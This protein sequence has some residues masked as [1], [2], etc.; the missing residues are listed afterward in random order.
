MAGSSM[1]RAARQSR[2]RSGG[3]A[4][5]GGG[6]GASGSLGDR[7]CSDTEEERFWIEKDVEF[8]SAI[9][10]R[11]LALLHHHKQ[12]SEAFLSAVLP[13][14]RSRSRNDAADAA[15][16]SPRSEASQGFALRV[17]V[18]DFLRQDW[19]GGEIGG[20]V[21]S[22][23]S[24][25]A[26]RDRR[27]EETIERE[28]DPPKRVS[29]S[30]PC[31]N[32][33]A[34]ENLTEG[35]AFSRDGR[36]T[37]SKDPQGAREEASPSCDSVASPVRR[38]S[39][40]S[41]LGISQPVSSEAGGEAGP[42]SVSSSGATAV[43]AGF[44]RNVP[45]SSRRGATSEGGE[46]SP[47]SQGGNSAS[48][49]VCSSQGPSPS[50]VVGCQG[51]PAPS[52]LSQ[53]WPHHTGKILLE[54]PSYSGETGRII[55]HMWPATLLADV[56]P[57]ALCSPPL[58]RA[59]KAA[60][61]PKKK[62][63][64]R[65]HARTGVEK[66]NFEES[67]RLSCGTEG[68]AS[69]GES[70]KRSPDWGRS[71]QPHFSS[72][73]ADAKETNRETAESEADG[74]K[75]DAGLGLSAHW[76]EETGKTEEEMK[77]SESRR[78]GDPSGGRK[79]G[80]EDRVREETPRG[81][82]GAEKE[83]T[84][85]SGEGGLA[86]AAWE[87]SKPK[88]LN[89]ETG[90]REGEDSSPSS[91]EVG[92]QGER[93][94]SRCGSVEGGER[95]SAGLRAASDD[96]REKSED[97][98]EKENDVGERQPAKVSQEGQAARDEGTLQNSRAGA[99]SLPASATVLSG[100]KR[101]LEQDGDSQGPRCGARSPCRASERS[102][103][104]ETMSRTAGR[105]SAEKWKREEAFCLQV[106]QNRSIFSL[107]PGAHD[108][109][110][111]TSLHEHQLN[112]HLKY[113]SRDL[114]VFSHSGDFK[115]RATSARG[116]SRRSGGRRGAR[117]AAGFDCE[118][119]AE[120]DFSSGSLASSTPSSPV[121]RASGA[122]ER[123][124][125]RRG[126]DSD[127]TPRR[128]GK[129]D[130]RGDRPAA[131][132][133][134][135]GV[136]AAVHEKAGA[137]S[138]GPSRAG[139][140]EVRVGGR[141]PSGE[142]E[143][144]QRSSPVGR[145]AK[146]VVEGGEEDP[147]EAGADDLFV[148]TVHK[149]WNGSMR[150]PAF[151]TCR[152]PDAF[153]LSMFVPPNVSPADFPEDTNAQGDVSAFLAV[154]ME[155]ATTTA[156]DWDAHANALTPLDGYNLAEKP[157]DCGAVTA[158]GKGAAE[159]LGA[160]R[161]GPEGLGFAG[162]EACRGHLHATTGSCGTQETSRME[163]GESVAQMEGERRAKLGKSVECDW[164]EAHPAHARPVASDYPSASHRRDLSKDGSLVKSPGGGRRRRRSS[165]TGSGGERTSSGKR[166]RSK[167]EKKRSPG[168][169]PPV[170][171]QPRSSSGRFM[172][173][174]SL[175]EVSPAAPTSSK[176]RASVSPSSSLA[177]CS[178]SPR[179]RPRRRLPLPTVLSG[180][181]P[182]WI[183]CSEGVPGPAPVGQG[184]RGP[185]GP[186]NA[187]VSS[188]ASHGSCCGRA[189]GLG[190][191]GPCW[192]RPVE[193]E[194]GAPFQIPGND[195][196]G[197]AGMNGE[198]ALD[199]GSE[200]YGGQARAEEREQSHAESEARL[201]SSSTTNASPP[202]HG[203]S[204]SSS[205]PPPER[206][207]PCLEAEG[208]ESSHA[209]FPPGQNY[210][211]LSPAT[212]TSGSSPFSPGASLF[213]RASPAGPSSPGSTSSGI[214]PSQSFASPPSSCP[215]F[216]FTGTGG[217]GAPS[218]AS[219]YH[220][221]SFSGRS[222]ACGEA[223]AFSPASPYPPCRPCA[224]IPQGAS[225]GPPPQF[226]GPAYQ[227]S[228]HLSP[229]SSA[230][231]GSVCAGPVSEAFS[232]VR[233]SFPSACCPPHPYPLFSPCPPA[234][235]QICAPGHPFNSYP[236][237]ASP[238]PELHCFSSAP[239][240]PCSSFSC[241]PPYPPPA[242]F[243]SAPETSSSSV[244]SVDPVASLSP[245]GAC[246]RASSAFS[247]STSSERSEEA[248][249]VPSCQNLGSG[250]THPS[251]FS[252][253]AYPVLGGGP[254]DTALCRPPASTAPP[255]LVPFTAFP[256]FPCPPL[257]GPGPVGEF[258]D[259]RPV[260]R[261]FPF[262]P[263]SSPA[264]LTL[265][266]FPRP[267]PPAFPGSSA[268]FEPASRCSSFL[269]RGEPQTVS[270]S[271]SESVAS[272]LPTPPPEILVPP[273]FGAG[274]S[275]KPFP[276]TC[277]LYP[278]EIA[279]SFR[280]SEKRK[281][282]V[283][284]GV[285]LELLRAQMTRV[286][287]LHT[288]YANVETGKRFFGERSF[289]DI[290]K[291]NARRH[292]AGLQPLSLSP[293]P[294]FNS[295]AAFFVPLT[296]ETEVPRSGS[297]SSPHTAAKKTKAT[298]EDSEREEREKR[299]K[300]EERGRRDLEEKI[301][302][303]MYSR[304]VV[305]ATT[306]H[307]SGAHRLMPLP[308]GK[309][310]A[311]GSSPQEL[312]IR[313]RDGECLHAS[314]GASEG[315]G[316]PQ[317]KKG[318][319]EDAQ[320]EH[321]VSLKT[322]A[323]P[324]TQEKRET[325]DRG[326][327]AVALSTLSP[328][329]TSPA[330]GAACGGQS[331]KVSPRGDSAAGCAE[332]G[333]ACGVTGE[334]KE[335][336]RASAQEEGEET[337]VKTEG[338]EGACE[339]EEFTGCV[340]VEEGESVGVKDVTEKEKE[341]C[342]SD[343]ANGE[344]RREQSEKE[345]GR[346]KDLV[347]KQTPF[348]SAGGEKENRG[349]NGDDRESADPVSLK[350][351]YRHRE[352]SKPV[353]DVA[354]PTLV[355]EEDAAVR[356]R[357]ESET[358]DVDGPE[359][360]GELLEGRKDS[361]VLSSRNATEDPDF[362]TKENEKQKAKGTPVASTAF[363]TEVENLLWRFS[364]LM[365]EKRAMCARL[366]MSIE[367]EKRPDWRAWAEVEDRMLRHYIEQSAKSSLDTRHTYT[368]TQQSRDILR[369]RVSC[370]SSGR[371]PPEWAERAL[372]TVCGSGED[373]DEDPIMFCDGCYQPV[374]FLCLG[375]KAVSSYEEFVKAS[376]MRRQRR[377]AQAGGDQGLAPATAR[378]RG[379]GPKR[380]KKKAAERAKEEKKK[381]RGGTGDLLASAGFGVP[382]PGA[383]SGD[384]AGTS[385]PTEGDQAGTGAGP[386]DT[387]HNT[388][389]P[390]CGAGGFAFR[391]DEEEWLC[392]VCEWLRK[393]LPQLDD[394]LALAA[395]RLAAGPRS[396]SEAA[397]CRGSYVGWHFE[398]L[399]HFDSWVKPQLLAL[400]YGDGRRRKGKGRLQV[401]FGAPQ[402]SR[403]DNRHGRKGAT[404]LGLPSGD[405]DS[406]GM[407][408]AHG[409]YS[410]QELLAWP[411][412]RVVADA[413]CLG[414]NAQ[415]SRSSTSRGSAARGPGTGG[416]TGGIAGP[417][418]D[419]SVFFRAEKDEEDRGL[420][421]LELDE[422]GGRPA[423]RG[424]GP[425]P[426]IS[427][428]AQTMLG[429]RT[430]PV[431]A[432]DEET[433][434]QSSSREGSVAGSK[435]G[436]LAGDGR[437][438]G[439][440]ERAGDRFMEPE[441]EDA[442]RAKGDGD[443]GRD[444]WARGPR[445]ASETGVGASGKSAREKHPV[446]LAAPE[447]ATPATDY[448]RRVPYTFSDSSGDEG[449]SG[450][451]GDT[452]FLFCQ[453]TAGSPTAS[454]PSSAAHRT[455]SQEDD[456]QGGLFSGSAFSPSSASMR[457]GAHASG[458]FSPNSAE[459]GASLTSKHYCSKDPRRRCVVRVFPVPGL[460]V[461]LRI[462]VCALCGYD[463]F[464][465]GGG[466]ARKTEKKGVW[467]HLRCALSLNAT[468]MDRVSYEADE[469][470]SRLR[471][472]FCHHQGPAP[473]HCGHA[474]CQ[475]TY[476]VSCATAT[477]GCMVDWD[478]G[479][480][481]IFCSQHAKNKAPTL[482]LRK[483]QAN[484]EREAVKRREE[485]LPGEW[486]IGAGK[487]RLGIALQSL[488]F[489]SY[490]GL[491]NIFSD[492]L[493]VPALRL[494]ALSPAEKTETPQ[495]LEALCF[496][497]VDPALGVHASPPGAPRDEAE[498]LERRR[499]AQSREEKAT[500]VEEQRKG[501]TQTED[502]TNREKEEKERQVE[503]GSG[504]RGES[505]S[506]DGGHDEEEERFTRKLTWRRRRVA[507]SDA[508]D[509]EG[510]ETKK[511]S[512]EENAVGRTAE[513]A[514]ASVERSR[515]C[516]M[517]ESAST[518]HAKQEV[519]NAGELRRKTDGDSSPQSHTPK[520]V[521]VIEGIEKLSRDD[522]HASLEEQEWKKEK[523]EE[524]KEKRNGETNDVVQSGLP[525]GKG[526]EAGCQSVGAAA[527]R[528]QG[529]SES[530]ATHKEPQK[531]AQVS[532]LSS[533]GDMTRVR[534]AGEEPTF[535]N[536]GKNDETKPAM[537]EDRGNV[538]VDEFRLSR[539]P[540]NQSRRLASLQ[541]D[542][543]EDEKEESEN[544]LA[545]ARGTGESRLDPPSALSASVANPVAV[546]DPGGE[547][548]NVAA[549][550]CSSP[551]SVP[552]GRGGPFSFA[553]QERGRS[554][555]GAVSGESESAT[556]AVAGEGEGRERARQIPNACGAGEEAR[557]DESRLD[558]QSGSAKDTPP[559]FLPSRA[560]DMLSLPSSSR[561]GETA[562]SCL[563][564]GPTPPGEGVSEPASSRVGSLLEGETGVGR[565]KR[566]SHSQAGAAREQDGV[567]RG[568][569][570][571]PT[572]FSSVDDTGASH[573]DAK[574]LEGS[575]SSL[576]SF[577]A[578]DREGGR[579]HNAAPGHKGA[580][581]SPTGVAAPFGEPV[582]NSPQSPFE[583][584][585]S[586]PPFSPD[587]WGE[588]AFFSSTSSF[589]SFSFNSGNPP[590]SS[591][592]P[593]APPRKRRGRPPLSRRSQGATHK[594][595]LHRQD[596]DR[597]SS[598]LKIAAGGGLSR[599]G[600][601][602][603]GGA[604]CDRD[605]RR[606]LHFG[607][608]RG[609]GMNLPERGPGGRFLPR[610]HREKNAQ[611]TPVSDSVSTS[612]YQKQRPV[613]LSDLSQG[614]SA[615]RRDGGGDS[616]GE[617]ESQENRELQAREEALHQQ[618]MR[619]MQI[620]FH[621]QAL[622]RERH[623][624]LLGN[625]FALT[626]LL[627][628][629]PDPAGALGL[630]A[631]H[632][633]GMPPSPLHGNSPATFFARRVARLL[634]SPVPLAIRRT[635]TNGSVGTAGEEK[636][637]G[638][639]GGAGQADTATAE[640]GVEEGPSGRAG[641]ERG[642]G[643]AQEENSKKDEKESVS[644]VS[645]GAADANPEAASRGKEALTK[646]A[647]ACVAPASFSSPV[648]Y[649][650]LTTIKDWGLPQ[651]TGDEKLFK[652]AFEETKA[653]DVL[654]LDTYDRF[655]ARQGV[656]NVSRLLDAVVDLLLFFI[657]R[658]VCCAGPSPA[659]LAALGEGKILPQS[660]IPAGFVFPLPLEL[661]AGSLAGGE[662]AKRA[663]EPGGSEKLC[664][665]E[666][667]T[668]DSQREAKTP[669]APPACSDEEPLYALI[670]TVRQ[671]GQVAELDFKTGTDA[672][673]KEEGARK[674][675][676]VKQEASE[677]QETDSGDNEPSRQSEVST[678]AFLDRVRKFNRQQ[679]DY[680]IVCSICG[681]LG[682]NSRA[683]KAGASSPAPESPSGGPSENPGSGVGSY[684]SSSFLRA[685]A[686]SAVDLLTCRCCNVR[687]CRACWNQTGRDAPPSFAVS[688][689]SG[690]LPG[691]KA[692]CPQGSAGAGPSSSAFIYSRYGGS[693][694]SEAAARAGRLQR[695]R[696]WKATEEDETEEED[697]D[698]GKGAGGCGGLL[699]RR[700]SRGAKDGA[701]FGRRERERDEKVDEEGVDKGGRAGTLEGERDDSRKRGQTSDREDPSLGTDEDEDELD[702]MKKRRSRTKQE[703][704]AIATRR[705]QTPVERDREHETQE[706]L[707]EE[708]ETDWT[709]LRCAAVLN[710]GTPFPSTRC[711]LCSRIDGLLVRRIPEDTPSLSNRKT[712]GNSASCSG[713]S[714]GRQTSQSASHA[715][716][717]DPPPERKEEQWVHW[718]CAEWLVPSRL[719]ATA[720]ENIR[721]IPK[722]A[723]EKPC[724]YCGIQQ[725]AT[726]GCCSNGFRCSASFHVSCARQLGC[727]METQRRSLD[728][729]IHRAYCLEHTTQ[730][731]RKLLQQRLASHKPFAFPQRKD[732]LDLN[733]FFDPLQ[734]LIAD[735]I[736]SITSL[737][738]VGI[739]LERLAPPSLPSFAAFMRPSS[740]RL[741][742]VEGGKHGEKEKRCRD[743]FGSR[744]ALHTN[745]RVDEQRAR[746]LKAGADRPEETDSVSWNAFD[747]NDGFF[748]A[749]R[750]KKKLRHH[751][752]HEEGLGERTQTGA[753]A[754]SE[755]E[756][757]GRRE[758]G[759]ESGDECAI[760]SACDPLLTPG[761]PS[762][763]HLEEQ[764]ELYCT[765]VAICDALYTQSR[766]FEEEALNLPSPSRAEVDA[767]RAVYS[768]SEPASPDL[769]DRRRWTSAFEV[770]DGL[771]DDENEKTTAG[772]TSSGST[773]LERG[774]G[775]ACESASKRRRVSLSS[776]SG[777]VS[778]FS[779]D[780]F[781]SAKDRGPPPCL[782]RS[783]LRSS[784]VSAAHASH[785]FDAGEDRGNHQLVTPLDSQ[786][787]VIDPAR[788]TWSPQESVRRP[789]F[790]ARSGLDGAV[791]LHDGGE[792]LPAP[793]L[794]L[795][796]EDSETP[797]E[798]KRQSRDAR[799]ALKFT[800]SAGNESSEKA[801]RFSP[802]RSLPHSDPKGSGANASGASP[803]P[804]QPSDGDSSGR[805]ATASQTV[806]AVSCDADS[807]VLPP[808]LLRGSAVD[809]PP[810]TA[811][812][813]PSASASAVLASESW[814]RGISAAAS[815]AVA[816]AVQAV[817]SRGDLDAGEEAEGAARER[818]EKQ[819]G[820]SLDVLAN[821]QMGAPGQVQGEKQPIF[822]PICKGMYNELP[823]GGPGD[824]FAWVGCDCCER[825]YH[826][827][828]SGFNEENPPPDDCDWICWFCTVK[829]RKKEEQ[830][831][832]RQTHGLQVKDKNRSGIK[833]SRSRPPPRKRD[834]SKR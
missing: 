780:A 256:P 685:C 551:S 703:K 331:A 627:L 309:C 444:A 372:C 412:V 163:S 519:L 26:G 829:I 744:S 499:G 409:A 795:S 294:S 6:E 631:L 533:T 651:H 5:S 355:K 83:E 575:H 133:R 629:S 319:T 287:G 550:N 247:G 105:T 233:H 544:R 156:S 766:A 832:E 61:D 753:S 512:P 540:E 214:R 176:P 435:G 417:G 419:G 801:S 258:E 161:N 377:V 120:G 822:C 217:P 600:R 150:L 495:G 89:G 341:G 205:L 682:K 614:G 378:E 224:S 27:S 755:G 181:L 712:G 267:S 471:C 820:E 167:D 199:K 812:V 168:T 619:H 834:R 625:D 811:D 238:F 186:L 112:A 280:Y 195:N 528:K 709:C 274:S 179:K 704:N 598:Y 231:P 485:D 124:R 595:A 385:R 462:P 364:A 505:E 534:Q 469:S 85:P 52:R 390:V 429:A 792:S 58:L 325:R 153:V 337:E 29:S 189:S 308:W 204:C 814:Y 661:P 357:G 225:S 504:A 697:T 673:Q 732:T 346:D 59:K 380:D 784:L 572:P 160:E 306:P 353:S 720:S 149:K 4:G 426:C 676:A 100:V 686:A 601:F 322:A 468:V 566:V 524:K 255:G 40:A 588:A 735:P 113:Q 532:C 624:R 73:S 321:L 198:R 642:R 9:N 408:Q 655:L 212:Q 148:P 805:G 669:S 248:A 644:G 748:E 549:E 211:G 405:T 816:H 558:R 93:P 290:A 791:S 400:Q 724:L 476:H 708:D 111:L 209:S 718:L 123:E 535:E 449:P 16:P 474:G 483:F 547:A 729:Q 110:L 432:T 142:R 443:F 30:P 257:L 350:E 771:M 264:S 102:P 32:R 416:E 757:E 667:E 698:E 688:Y 197:S 170:S 109:A 18:R 817:S 538:C 47:R 140:E 721:S 437:R 459:P 265:T 275:L 733:R 463:A 38:C 560:S 451:D 362:D 599:G 502:V 77:D 339:K 457:S 206:S 13:Y 665:A 503:G 681:A 218:P 597:V 104:E 774:R 815:M 383:G 441:E 423:I 736:R 279:E 465:R 701:G 354:E 643:G 781:S 48:S 563:P 260:L 298:K 472:L 336:N 91:P 80:E 647:P 394:E 292:D 799:K 574:P 604:S 286:D 818:E 365:D 320:G 304:H 169:G 470:R 438:F 185:S 714:T 34:E 491:C 531:E 345:P 297:P 743:A 245:P 316:G 116:I 1:Q 284:S 434:K 393:Q 557:G 86:G 106:N 145:E 662:K 567:S 276:P 14:L 187:G 623:R 360:R 240:P 620:L 615:D 342:T 821:L 490:D 252:A 70:Q 174:E 242:C 798:E 39:S 521:V 333:P 494:P 728:Q 301:R 310:D 421:K 717:A 492:L 344:A 74:S 143:P 162:R 288:F 155:A 562:G 637:R 518:V 282:M 605:K 523:A 507:D 99:P 478:M 731:N 517:E 147:D 587:G 603:L 785:F 369:L 484:R 234:H 420:K 696:A 7:G 23:T 452:P 486:K 374:H 700:E 479:R 448:I 664:E 137:G 498:A 78:C 221:C 371:L 677:R 723:F 183:D 125:N 803:S 315:V 407:L 219:G 789:S 782:T 446:S 537:A 15:G 630:G 326:V 327:A 571:T 24:A 632:A 823:D 71:S 22:G 529:F 332:T 580:L 617:N 506:G 761:P 751:D 273:F 215:P 20:Y 684:L 670:D 430:L 726:L 311:S 62:E 541:K 289:F 740:L 63:D 747:E 376:T 806:S 427:S 11:L 702:E 351:F 594:D 711:I 146:A 424:A 117:V 425:K 129:G 602:G 381:A 764:R 826:W 779:G 154:V 338:R 72:V 422:G 487:G 10:P 737:F 680:I 122:R 115:R 807:I 739:H 388:R 295:A 475:R 592:D 796:A 406:V 132:R 609:S 291:E 759:L 439:G 403:K 41:C 384:A 103:K 180:P 164:S 261:D 391:E 340:S 570:R 763:M 765:G 314:P 461:V 800:E 193:P 706:R 134:R 428:L 830:E 144:N 454:S 138:P 690:S 772:R 283:P 828:C 79:D 382:V 356:E 192:G 775:V 191:P 745:G 259:R 520:N 108:P 584:S 591:S 101:E 639:L 654:G 220:P 158:L 525:S 450:K 738:L 318:K 302:M 458:G 445:S 404:G 92:T 253:P 675:L 559:L 648:D 349:E 646:E 363:G 515:E 210:G 657:L 244:S 57:S 513:G 719:A 413:G 778:C 175:T 456:S 303:H 516:G 229:P 178:A 64:S 488:L 415:S 200:M 84:N 66:K 758:R 230:P 367:R 663:E 493:E 699:A 607:G 299:E 750:E 769:R 692:S 75:T 334:T 49:R 650:R 107:V 94:A 734:L 705:R 787:R 635:S 159:R 622:T 464:C 442:R 480:P 741:S 69:R 172:R 579:V 114:S 552:G 90:S 548:E 228:A 638:A 715:H 621:L 577:A 510:K 536:R 36:F 398:R 262:V 65:V 410:V 666:E 33:S 42:S 678:Q 497:G 278:P 177:V 54:R 201:R 127:F 710:A 395:I 554:E 568:G 293:L 543:D 618:R 694:N 270:S 35:A 467:A 60:A 656:Q 440:G 55:R 236:S 151:P 788:L 139:R 481:V 447:D 402:G 453:Y 213:P 586:M 827:T 348:S 746:Y 707:R 285:R 653:A 668:E 202:K 56:E 43:A 489:P 28:S 44:A 237:E 573:A 194:T 810:L 786:K 368:L 76:S 414:P 352:T 313:A 500:S 343:T 687:V 317:E 671:L 375:H 616:G 777:G 171:P 232:S 585:T 561:L 431:W 269:P 118:E 135:D 825:W 323:E 387:C 760:S 581:A 223:P 324:E 184:P 300:D 246:R 361:E 166:R 173:R 790:L 335:V 539:S 797:T 330:P 641:A 645:A 329:K 392:P 808:Y 370:T 182:A 119:T 749:V 121:A 281:M 399:E 679:E 477:P 17:P 553:V 243:L 188:S 8:F 660:R 659:L 19:T 53:V 672:I 509:F 496:P 794:T 249:G 754:W 366:L 379:S 401:D 251:C 722:L 606:S 396:Q 511:K 3:R 768:V 831:R 716:P 613:S 216:A 611:Q 649:L 25:E 222:P 227:G 565:G 634:D 88:I 207:G 126:S 81:S 593:A 466:P 87:S 658:G 742:A 473:G 695:R 277:C 263:A 610:G 165:S 51:H 386:G 312:E 776:G 578:L 628:G 96:K 546:A 727:R 272:C 68:T 296:P 767:A 389:R 526:E 530:H 556:D 418:G 770:T 196:P 691:A 508:E 328:E 756:R 612:S 50:P 82:S 514:H 141:A 713:S 241:P 12:S 590:S 576:S 793:A 569:S 397:E 433:G 589:R 460:S 226:S 813:S 347:V 358:M 250:A 359:A 45:S 501:N 373:W 21:P 208:T 46:N 128:P 693:Y 203:P 762:P 436:R 157:G 411:A 783:G 482:I 819:S 152:P 305:P 527:S 689:L 674:Q 235:P 752:R 131:A 640:T 136:F 95:R 833:H 804:A 254:A 455:P 271:S 626:G 97:R 98:R 37:C 596:R 564:N 824:G 31:R 2:G 802:D 633:A 773:S 730:M 239:P 809:L 266:L 542:R 307:L 683:A 545:G 555:A 636:A 522:P 652:C 725:G 268:P 190:M 582:E 583:T 130:T 67:S 608:G